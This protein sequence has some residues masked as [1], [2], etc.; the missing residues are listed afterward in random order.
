MAGEVVGAGG[1]IKFTVERTGELRLPAPPPA[2][3]EQ[4]ADLMQRLEAC[5]MVPILD[6][7]LVG[8]NCG[9]AAAA[10]GV[11]GVQQGVVVSCSGKAPGAVLQAG[12][13]VLLARF[14][15]AAWAA[16]YTSAAQGAAPTSDSPL[17]W[18][19][20][21]SGAAERYA[22]CVPPL[23]AVHG[24]VLAEGAGRPVCVWVGGG[25]GGPA[26]CVQGRLMQ[27]AGSRLC[28]SGASH[29]PLPPVAAPAPLRPTPPAA[30][31]AGLEA[32]RAAGLPI[33][34]RATLF[35]T[36]DDLEALEA[37][38]RWARLR[39]RARCCLPE[40]EIRSCHPPIC[41]GDCPAGEDKG[42]LG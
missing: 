26:G 39:Q 30:L 41:C 33:S 36:P 23:V 17:H 37:L 16:Q 42:R 5:G 10:A 6:D 20:L 7:G 14:D 35:S 31:H 22:W 25:G 4:L 38:F 11:D 2:P 13:W 18:A 29:H 15:R 1:R 8:G 27:P 12:D 40:F 28:R 19:A 21:A 34:D 9:V 3:L 32:A 24:H